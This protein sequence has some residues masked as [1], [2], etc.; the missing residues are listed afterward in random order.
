M[1]AL[2]LSDIEPTRRGRF[3][4]FANGEFLF[5]VDGETLRKHRL[6]IGGTLSAAQLDAL[7]EASDTRAAKDK[8]LVYLSLRS[9]GS[10][11]LYEKLC[12]SFD[13]RTAAAAV[14]EMVRL[15]LLDDPAFA[16]RRARWLSGQGK[17][18]RDI[19][20]RL[21]AL[22]LDRDLVEE[23]LAELPDDE[24]DKLCR[25]I[26]KQ[27]L[28]RLQRGERDK[29]LAALLRRGF[30]LFAA[31]AAIDRFAPGADDNTTCEEF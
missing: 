18:R 17:S 11:E 8:A 24:Q 20:Q 25:L 13:E 14:A 3:A 31:R 16:R 6:E 4:L 27:Y 7:R 30:S 22:G 10:A 15:E 12:R 21:L 2:V 26:E 5:S 1:D 9:Y 29:V 19:R 23:V 28:S